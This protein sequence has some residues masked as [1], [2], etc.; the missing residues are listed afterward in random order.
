MLR[1]IALFYL[2]EYS[3]GMK[4]PLLLPLMLASLLLISS[5]LG[6]E[7]VSAQLNKLEQA[8]GIASSRLESGISSDENGSSDFSLQAGRQLEFAL[9]SIDAAN[10]LE[11]D[12]YHFALY[13]LARQAGHYR[14][15]VELLSFEYQLARFSPLKKWLKQRI[16]QLNALASSAG[17]VDK[18]FSISAEFASFRKMLKKYGL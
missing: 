3:V 4:K 17:G 16:D 9:L 2:T 5:A 13:L 18:N 7:T 8:V 14:L 11:E 15:A 6:A 10:L 12:Y 1:E